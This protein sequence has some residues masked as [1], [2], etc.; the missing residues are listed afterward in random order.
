LPVNIQKSKVI[1]SDKKRLVA[2]VF[3]HNY[4]LQH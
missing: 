3:W 2:A 4:L 1:W